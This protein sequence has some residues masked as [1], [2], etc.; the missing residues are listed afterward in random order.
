MCKRLL[1]EGV[2][3]NPIISPAVPPGQALI[4]VSIMATHTKE[5]LQSAL[6]VFEVVGKRLG[7]I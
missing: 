2:Y 4:R 6:N 7:I 3:V 1:E 5:Q